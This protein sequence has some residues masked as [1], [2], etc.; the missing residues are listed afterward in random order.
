MT[1]GGNTQGE[2]SINW[3][4]TLLVP[5]DRIEAKCK[6]YL[7]HGKPI[8]RKELTTNSDYSIVAGYQAE[9]RGVVNYYR[10]AINLRDLT[11]LK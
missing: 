4:P 8:H 3:Q 1:S 2:R 10:M 5:R 11:K 6:T 9:Y 7:L